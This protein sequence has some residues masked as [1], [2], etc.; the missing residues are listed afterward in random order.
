[1]VKK[2]FHKFGVDWKTKSKFTFRKQLCGC[3]RHLTT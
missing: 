3:W 1:M 2:I